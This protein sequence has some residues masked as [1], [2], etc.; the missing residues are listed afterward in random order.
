MATTIY[1]VHEKGGLEGDVRFVREGFS[2][3]AFLFTFLWLWAHRAW[4]A[5]LAVLGA[6]LLLGLGQGALGISDHVTIAAQFA[7]SAGVGIFGNDLHRA[8]LARRG[9]A[10]TGLS[11]GDSVDEAEI[12]YFGKRLHTA[13]PAIPA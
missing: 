10:E 7:I 1:T 5:G 3:W 4:L 6:M 13:A 8:A 9:F 12:R 11:S 2:V